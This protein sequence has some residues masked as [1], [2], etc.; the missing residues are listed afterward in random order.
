MSLVM[1]LKKRARWTWKHLRLGSDLHLD[2]SEDS[3]TQMNLLHIAK[4]HSDEIAIESY[5]RPRERSLG[6][7]W[8]WW[9]FQGNRGIGM[10]VQAKRINKAA[11]CYT[12]IHYKHKDN[13]YQADNLIEKSEAEQRI[14]LF[15][16]YNFWDY[17]MSRSAWGGNFPPGEKRLF[18]CSLLSPYVVKEIRGQQCDCSIETFLQYQDPW[19]K[20]FTS[21]CRHTGNQCK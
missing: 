16:L 7:D 8:E 20:M 1:T 5:S 13:S 12:H 21:L 9:Y 3:L 14:P 19:H 6:A 11:T 2:V 15:V 17:R 18:G 10:R 4:A